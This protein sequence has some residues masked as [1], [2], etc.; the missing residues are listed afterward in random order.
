MKLL[1]RPVID[2]LRMECVLVQAWKKTS[3]H[4]RQHSWYADTL[5]LDYQSLRLPAFIEE[6]QE[7]LNSPNEWVS[8]PLDHIPAPKA[9]RWELK[10]EKWQPKQSEKLATKLR[11]LAHLDLQ[12]QVVATAM[13][14]CLADRVETTAGDPRLPPN[15]ASNR[16]RVLAYG[17]RLFCDSEDG[18]L[19]HRWGS[20]KL[21]RQFYQDY[22]VFL[23]RPKIVASEFSRDGTEGEIAI[24]HSDLSK[25]YDRV[26]PKLLHQKVREMQLPSDDPEFFALFEKVFDWKWRNSKWPLEYG[27]NNGIDDFSSVALPQG[28]VAA[29]F[30]ANIAL[31]DFENALRE[32]IDQQM[33]FSDGVDILDVCYYVDDLRIVLR[34]AEGENENL[35]ECGVCAWLQTLLERTAPGL[36]VEQRKTKATVE[37]REKR[38]LVPQSKAA[39]RIQH[40][41]SGTFD[42]LHGTEL[43]GAIEGF[44][45]TQQRYASA[46]MGTGNARSGLLIGISDL[47]DDTA[48]RFAAGRYRR[49]FRSLRPLLPSDIARIDGAVKSEEDDN[50]GEIGPAQLVLSREQLDEKAQL[51][52]AMLIE[53]WV[54]NP[55]NVRLL[56]IALDMY[57]EVRFLDEIL[58]LLRDGWSLN[59][60]RGP[61]K[62]VRLYC[63]A[64][65]FR[66]GATETGM[67]N[68]SD[69]LPSDVDVDDYHVR[70]ATEAGEIFNAFMTAPG[71]SARLPWFFMQQV[72][73]Y[74]CARNQVPEVSS[75]LRRKSFDRLN[76]HRQLARFISGNQPAQ[77]QERSIY[78][79]LGVSAF[80]HE[81]LLSHAASGNVSPEFLRALSE[82]SPEIAERLWALISDNATQEQCAAARSLGIIQPASTNSTRTTVGSLAQTGTN[83]FYEEENLLKLADRLLDYDYADWPEVLTPW[84]IACDLHQALEGSYFGLIDQKSVA[85]LDRFPQGRHLFVIPDWCESNDEKQRYKL[86]M[87]LRYALRSSINFNSGVTRKKDL[88]SNL[89]YRTPVSHWEQQRHSGFQGRSSFAP[90]WLPMSSRMETIL[91]ELLR[92]PGCGVSV[93]IQSMVEIAESI[94]S[95]L[96]E[97]GKRRGKA[98]K[99]I[100]LEQA[101]SWPGKPPMNGWERPLR[102]GIVQSVVPDFDQYCAKLQDP[103]LLTDPTLRTQQRSHLAALLEGVSQMLR[104][105]ET[106]RSQARQD[107]RVLD[108]LVFPELAVHPLDVD[109][110]I[111]PFVRSYKCIVLCGLVYHSESTLQGAPLINSCLWLIPEWSRS[112]GFQ[113]RRFEQG[114]KHLA[115]G[116][117]GFSPPIQ[118]FRPVQWQIEYQWH[119]DSV[120]HR[121][122][123]L[124][125]S[126]CYDATDLELAADLR[127]RNDFYIVC[128]LNRDVGTFD[129]MAEGLHYH[130][131]QAVMVV[132]NGQFGGSNLFFPFGETHHR[133]VLHLHGQPQASIAFAEICPRKLIDRPLSPYS[134]RP[135]GAWKTKP[136]GWANT[137]GATQSEV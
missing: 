20:S 56:R 37:G 4:I 54:S 62:D 1:L 23:E 35:I 52:A 42:M 24:V 6:L 16:K 36:L 130:M 38:F 111:L 115:S 78:L 101:A 19:T 136:A 104:V 109:T 68:D 89:R 18:R 75:G 10:D 123:I 53:E 77:L 95:R 121:P 96:K 9:Q 128:A 120:M 39:K 132:N 114:K 92:W 14:M 81:W 69:C 119:S 124:S 45:H 8:A 73:L 32:S 61:R 108:L 93:P 79:V 100:F 126:I 26:R 27:K 51:F 137:S 11:P 15:E 113:V 82:V 60:G 76:R 30:F 105:R 134:A 135:E 125:A 7:R 33:D 112:S 88:V 72:F 71:S 29:G 103:E 22:Q 2:D 118:G 55:G 5:E 97:L 13:M 31:R 34:I 85:I 64:E 3:A 17:H 90:P 65:I 84:Q 116:E 107:G 57:P 44:F 87:V 46:D 50:D 91:F 80:G 98:T 63:L 94:K 28:L 67:V 47:R 99:M 21:Y 122:L 117:A 43:I 74:L 48:T 58:G 127:N 83:P 133:Q 102:V 59:G 66:A 86:G 131:F 70:L 110:L 49:T 25:F 106:H 12:D 129:R 41:V 40:E